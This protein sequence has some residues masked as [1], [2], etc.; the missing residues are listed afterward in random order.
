MHRI[1]LAASLLAFAATPA[2][3]GDEVMAGYFGNTIVST[4]GMFT[5]N[6]HYR[7]DHSFDVVGSGMGMTRNYKGTWAID[8]KGQLCRTYVGDTPPG[9]P[10]NPLCTPWEA[11]K[12]GDKWTV[13]MGGNSRDLELKAGVQ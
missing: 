10:S 11:H 5:A 4:G 13:T 9:L 6:T 12:V 2:L 1:L 8:G 3:A 7:A